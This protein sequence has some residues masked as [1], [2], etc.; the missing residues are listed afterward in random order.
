ALRPACVRLAVG[1]A[2]GRV[3][4]KSLAQT[5]QLLLP[6]VALGARVVGGARCALALEVADLPPDAG[7]LG[8]VAE[9]ARH[10]L[11]VALER[12]LEFAHL[13]CHVDDAPVGLELREARLENL[14]GAV[15]A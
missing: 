11:G 6:A 5:V 3:L 15:P 4:A 9:V 8:E 10:R 13:A 2:V 12:A 1:A 7:V 14:A